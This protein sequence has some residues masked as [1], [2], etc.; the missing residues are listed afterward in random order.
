MGEL[1]GWLEQSGCRPVV[2]ASHPRSGTHLLIDTLR[3]NF[4]DCKSWKWWGERK[5]RLY[6]NVISLNKC[7]NLVSEVRAMQ[8]L[9][10]ARNPIVK[11]HATADLTR[12]AM[13]G[14]LTATPAAEV[15]SWMK[16]HSKVLYTYRDG[17]NALCSLF[18]VEREWNNG[19]PQATFSEYIRQCPNGKSRVREWTDHVRGWID[20]YRVF[21]VA[22]EEL[23][24]H[25]VVC[26]RGIS[27]YLGLPCDWQH[28]EIPGITPN[29]TA[30]R[31]DR[32]FCTHP[33]STAVIHRL[34]GQTDWRKHFTPKDREFFASESDELLVKL[35][36]EEDN[37]WVDPVN[38]SAPHYAAGFFATV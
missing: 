34:S 20:D 8:I 15:L 19:A 6:L 16:D 38:D 24:I 3:L 35:G 25:P 10:R 18:E 4:P 31:I 29:L 12:D 5:D 7:R 17:R 26:L 14:D 27:D 37:S 30:S 28:C 11:T 32:L 23:L 21:C 1:T 13:D 36:Y 33:S 9:R 22:M 2:V